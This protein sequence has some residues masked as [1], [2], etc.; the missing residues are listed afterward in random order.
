MNNLTTPP[1]VEELDPQYVEDLRA[2]LV[3]TARGAQRHRSIWT[4]VLAAACGV[5]VI[6]G[7]VVASTRAGGHSGSVEPAGPQPTVAQQ[8]PPKDSERINLDRGSAFIGSGVGIVDA[9][10]ARKCLAEKKSALGQPNPA[11]P[12]DVSLDGSYLARLQKTLPGE[13]GL[14]E[15]LRTTLLIQEFT[16]LAGVQVECYD[17][18]LLYAFDPAAVPLEKTLKLTSSKPV[19]GR[20]NFSEI[21]DGNSTRLF[22]TY[23]FAALPGVN[24]VQVRIRWTG[25]ASPWYVVPAYFGRGYA[26]ASQLGAVHRPGLTEVDYRAVDKDGKVLFSGVERG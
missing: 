26:T 2:N 6:T 19:N 12:A 18:K 15:P 24:E 11:T 17:D 1:P 22:V 25:G 10:V 9:A 13:G 14:L 16:T 20:W 21:P 3:R 8:V 5:A 7:G 23:T 4:P